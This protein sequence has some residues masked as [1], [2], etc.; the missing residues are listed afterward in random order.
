RSDDGVAVRFLGIAADITARKESE[1]EH[2][3][4]E[5]R[6]SFLAQATS[7]LATSL[8]YDETLTRLANLAVPFLADWCGVDVLEDDGSIRRVAVAY[9]DPDQTEPA[10]R[11]SVP[12]DPGWQTGVPEVIRSGR[13]AVMGDLSDEQLAAL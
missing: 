3:G 7:V 2:E 12:P 6:L 9:A 8:D 10:R 4:K 5:R 11:L 1:L 13:P